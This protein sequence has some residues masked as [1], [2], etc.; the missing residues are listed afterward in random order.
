MSDTVAHRRRAE[1]SALVARHNGSVTPS[2]VVDYATNPDTALHSLFT[3]D[4][5]EAAQSW[6][7]HQAAKYLRAVVTLVPHPS[8]DMGP[9]AVRAFVSLSTDRRDT[10]VYRPIEAVMNDTKHRAVLIA[11]AV[12]ELASVRAK[13]GHLK[14][15]EKVWDAIASVAVAA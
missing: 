15:L 8:S 14:E 1:L 5:G 2:Q 6:R 9:I 4:D 13:H 11:D 12:N 10:G 3:W 7:E